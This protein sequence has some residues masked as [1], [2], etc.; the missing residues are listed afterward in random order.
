MG[1]ASESK[2]VKVNEGNNRILHAPETLVILFKE[3]GT[4][5]LINAEAYIKVDPVLSKNIYVN[6][7][8]HI[9]V[10]IQLEGDCKGVYVT[11]KT[12]D[13]FKVKEL[14]SGSSNVSF[15]FNL[16]ANRADTLNADGDLSSINVK[17]RP[18]ISPNKWEPN[19]QTLKE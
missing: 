11:Y 8:H 18:L 3:F 16:V 17:D 4:T 12:K 9:K 6:D 7:K 2:M 15:L 14:Q 19:E 10:F 13:G 5:Q 1:V